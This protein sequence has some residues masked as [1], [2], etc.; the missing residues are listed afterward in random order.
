MIFQFHLTFTI[1]YGFQS[2]VEVLIKFTQIASGNL[3]YL[4]KITIF[5]GYI[6][7]IS[8]AIFHSYV[9]NY[10]RVVPEPK[11]IHPPLGSGRL[12]R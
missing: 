2:L 12:E 11:D 10:Q 1:I 7:T 4:W 9:T 3:T 8:M 6:S 5:N